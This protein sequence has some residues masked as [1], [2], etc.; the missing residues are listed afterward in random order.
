[1]TV[2]FRRNQ[3]RRAR[4]QQI[5]DAASK[6]FSEKGYYQATIE[7]IE[8]ASGLTRGSIYYHFQGKEEIYFSVLACGLRMLRDELRWVTRT[9][10]T[11]AEE[12]AGRLLDTYCEFS[13]NHE[14]YFRILQYFYFGW[15][16]QERLREDL[17]DE[18]NRIIF[19]CLSEVVDMIERGVKEGVFSVKDPMIEAV[20]IWSLIGSAL[21]K[22]TDN[23]RA[24]FLGIQWETMKSALKEK[25]LGGLKMGAQQKSD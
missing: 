24:A 18:I 16:R 3:E 22:T 11:G 7:D 23:P 10:R 5:V 6:V 9:S 13:R 14:E 12:L 20:L 25:I 21:R 4:W 2:R 8:C 17:V 1:M 19:D 15:D